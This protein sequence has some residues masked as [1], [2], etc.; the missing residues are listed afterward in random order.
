MSSDE[1]G[2]ACVS[3][4]ASVRR[5]R[6]SFAFL[7]GAGVELPRFVV[8]V[9]AAFGFD[10]LDNLR[11]LAALGRDFRG[12]FRDCAVFFLA[13]AGRFADARRADGAF[14]PFRTAFAGAVRLAALRLAIAS[15]LS[16]P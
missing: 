11:R 3:V 7:T 6:S 5:T 10:L 14:G 13:D 8:T 15:V 1:G 12:G 9:E 2:V 4:S 16:E